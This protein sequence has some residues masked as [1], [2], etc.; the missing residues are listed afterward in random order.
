MRVSQE[1]VEDA[2]IGADSMRAVM[3]EAMPLPSL[4]PLCLYVD[5]RQVVAAFKRTERQ[6]EAFRQEMR[7]RVSQ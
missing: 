2:A 1:V 4:P 3:A 7:R 6:L 5:E